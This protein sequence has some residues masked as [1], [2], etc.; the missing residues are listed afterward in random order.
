LT[1]GYLSGKTDDPDS[2]FVGDQGVDGLVDI[3]GV[4]GEEGAEDDEN[5][6]RTVTRCVAML[7]SLT[8]NFKRDEGGDEV[9]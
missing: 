3:A 2:Y 1:D 7:V 4:G 5:F 9:R 8:G 6:S